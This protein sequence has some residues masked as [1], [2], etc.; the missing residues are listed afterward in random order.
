MEPFLFVFIVNQQVARRAFPKDG[1]FRHGWAVLNTAAG[2]GPSMELNFRHTI[3]VPRAEAWRIFHTHIDRMAPHLPDVDRIHV[4]REQQWAGYLEHEVAWAINQS[5][6]PVSARPFIGRLV[7][8]LLSTLSWHHDHNRVDFRF[9]NDRLPELFDCQGQAQLNE[10][11]QGT[12][13]HITAELDIQPHHLP[14]VPRWLGQSV[15]PSVKRVVEQ[16]LGRILDAL[17]GAVAR[18]SHDEAE[19]RTG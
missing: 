13:I 17:P 4:R 7:E 12:D 6:V 9:Y 10:H 19:Q 11:V 3:D 1:G 8:E 18:V 5:V 14:G 16:T 15:R 2:S